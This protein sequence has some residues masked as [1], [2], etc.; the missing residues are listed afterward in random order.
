[1]LVAAT[2][3]EAKLLVEREL[4]RR[5]GTCTGVRLFP[6]P[7]AD[8]RLVIL[9]A[10]LSDGTDIEVLCSLAWPIAISNDGFFDEA[11]IARAFEMP[12]A[13]VH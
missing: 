13:A 4:L 9:C 1:M 2:P 11:A 6:Y 12:S 10:E 7:C 8:R 3:A 5:A